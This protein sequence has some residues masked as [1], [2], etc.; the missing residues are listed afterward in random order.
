MVLP[1]PTPQST[2]PSDRF[3][4][5]AAQVPP[6]IRARLPLMEASLPKLEAL[7]PF[8]ESFWTPFCL[9]GEVS[10]AVETPGVLTGER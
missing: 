5:T 3:R 6:F 10:C 1:A 9:F 8:L 4:N 7:L 2:S